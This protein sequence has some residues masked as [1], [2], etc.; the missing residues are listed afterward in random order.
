MP[1]RADVSDVSVCGVGTALWNYSCPTCCDFRGETWR[2][3][4]ATVL[5]TLPTSYSCSTKLLYVNTIIIPTH[6]DPGKSE[7]IFNKEGTYLKNF[8]QRIA[9]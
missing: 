3:S 1:P 2:S 8:Q 5:L 9:E 4:H 6:C 7:V